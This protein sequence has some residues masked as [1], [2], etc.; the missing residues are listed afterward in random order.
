MFEKNEMLLGRKVAEE[1]SK[2]EIEKISG[3]GDPFEVTFAP[4]LEGVE[5]CDDTV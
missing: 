1:L 3:G 4:S 2:D 5:I